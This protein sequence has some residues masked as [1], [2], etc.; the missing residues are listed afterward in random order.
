MP[1][2][3]PNVC[4]SWCDVAPCPP[5]PPTAKPLAVKA[6]GKQF[7]SSSESKTSGLPTAEP[8]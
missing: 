4:P 8:R 5:Q 6:I 7:V 2:I 1:N 3:R